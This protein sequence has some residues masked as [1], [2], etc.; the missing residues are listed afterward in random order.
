MEY[1]LTTNSLIHVSGTVVGNLVFDHVTHDD[2]IY[3]GYIKVD[4]THSVNSDTLMFF[5]NENI[6]D[7]A[8]DWDGY[9]LDING[10]LRAYRISENSEKKAYKAIIYAHELASEIAAAED[11]NTVE[12]KGDIVSEPKLRTTPSGKVI[13]DF[14]LSVERPHSKTDWIPC[15]AWGRDAK[16]ISGELEEGTKIEVKGRLQSRQFS[17]VLSD[18]TVSHRIVY[19]VCVQKFKEANNDEQ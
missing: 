19:E 8:A 6:I 7:V 10:S 4:R 11:C 1:T 14:M 16:Y 18:G 15:I 3:K 5:V 12:L 13:C 2:K 17:K 9:W